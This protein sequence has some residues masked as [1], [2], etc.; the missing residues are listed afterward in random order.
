[1]KTLILHTLFTVLTL[2][3]FQAQAHDGCLFHSADTDAATFYQT[4]AN[5]VQTRTGSM[6]LPVVFH[7]FN[8]SIDEAII[9]EQLKALN[10]DFHGVNSDIDNVPSAFKKVVGSS[11][12]TFE[13]ANI[14]PDGL[15]TSG[16]N[17][18][19]SVSLSSTNDIEHQVKKTY[20]WDAHAYINIYIL[21][22]PKSN[23]K[24]YAFLPTDRMVGSMEDGI[25][26]DYTAVGS[27]SSNGVGRTLTHEMGHFLGLFHT[28]GTM[29]SCNSD[30]GI[31]DTP[32]CSMPTYSCS[33]T[34][35][36]ECGQS[37]MFMN[38]MD[39]APDDCAIMFTQMQV[40]LMERI[41]RQKRASLLESG[42]ANKAVLEYLVVDNL[43]ID[44]AEA[45]LENWEV[46][47]TTDGDYVHTPMLSFQKSETVVF[48]FKSDIIPT[49]E[50]LGLG[51]GILDTDI[52]SA[53]DIQY[54]HHNTT[55]IIEVT[56]KTTFETRIVFNA[57]VNQLQ[58]FSLVREATQA[59]AL[60]TSNDDTKLAVSIGPN[61]TADFVRI[62]STDATSFH[63]QVYSM[64][65]Q[66]MLSQEVAHA[67]QTEINLQP[68]NAGNYVLVLNH[69]K[70]ASSYTIMKL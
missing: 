55:T 1:M 42:R 37:K 61:P 56:P 44:F 6:E 19:P 10:E 17:Y 22:I 34:A 60:T 32:L 41:V 62:T 48:T 39:Y 63:L 40:A 57:D 36:S 43:T 45:T 26:L 8:E 52:E 66:L 20:G 65:G 58:S 47:H 67:T 59:L 49:V 2:L 18:Y 23:V 51:N 68:F 30:D 28:W 69:D 46:E 14:S 29:Y 27:V 25:V 16:I 3:S 7:V 53:F 12:I 33:A 15:P 54:A 64:Q 9:L 11:N 50:A 70:K 21:D 24:G 4:L 5:Q 38:F 31:D 35:I 13:L